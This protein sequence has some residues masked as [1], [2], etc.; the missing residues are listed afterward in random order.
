MTLYDY[1]AL[2]NR[3]GSSQ[4]V[5]DYGMRPANNPKSL[6]KQLAMTVNKEGESALMKIADI[7]P[8]KELFDSHSNC[9]G[10]CSCGKSNFA[11][12]NGQDLKKE[13]SEIK[14][15]EGISSR[16]VDMLIIGGIM[17]V[18]LALIIKK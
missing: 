15:N 6:A 8:D 10:S 14:N 7:H 3:N 11:G 17:V 5:M 4:L 2:N 13:V 12:F 16:T 18:A 1:V 9:S